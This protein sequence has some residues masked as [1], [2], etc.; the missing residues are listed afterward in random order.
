MMLKLL[1]ERL[2]GARLLVQN[3]GL[4]TGRLG[5]EPSNLV[6]RSLVVTMD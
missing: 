3:D 6:L 2:A 4:D 5:D 1:N